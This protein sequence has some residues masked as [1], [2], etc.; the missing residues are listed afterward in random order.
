M[1]KELEAKIRTKEGIISYLEQREASLALYT[2]KEIDIPI[3]E[4]S[5]RITLTFKN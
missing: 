2:L 3:L 1:I 4:L 5:D